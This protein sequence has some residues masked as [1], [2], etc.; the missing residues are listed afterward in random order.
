MNYLIGRTEHMR[1]ILLEA[2]HTRQTSQRTACFV[3]MQH[4]KVGHTNRQLAVGTIAMR[5]HQAVTGAVHRLQCKLFLLHIK[6]EHVLL[7]VL[8]VAGLLP[9]L[10]IVD[11]GRDD[12]F[13]A[14]V[15]ILGL[16]GSYQLRH[17]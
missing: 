10:D 2:T 8:P 5:K 14:K 16:C 1:V 9:Q 17:V 4:T 6:G 12:L 11:V 3:A 13:I 7:V 15:A